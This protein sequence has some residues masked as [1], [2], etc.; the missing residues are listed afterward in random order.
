MRLFILLLLFCCFV[1]SVVA[2]KSADYESQTRSLLNYLG[3]PRI[4]TEDVNRIVT[5]REK[6]ESVSYSAEERT[7]TFEELFHELTRLTGRDTVGF[8]K[9]IRGIAKRVITDTL[10][11]F[12]PLKYSSTPLNTLAEVKKIGSGP[13]P[14][15]LIPEYRKN[16]TIYRKFI[17]QNKDK[18]TMY[19]LTLPGYNGTNP[20]PLPKNYDFSIHTWL[21]S[22]VQGTINLIKKEKIDKPLIIGSLNAGSYICTQLATKIPDQLR[23]V[24]LLNGSR[25]E[26]F[27]FRPSLSPSER[28]EQVNNDI[29]D[30]FWYLIARKKYS[31]S[32]VEARAVKPR[33]KTHPINLYSKDSSTVNE[34]FKMHITFPSITERYDLEWRTVDLTEDLRKISTPTMVIL[35]KY[36]KNRPFKNNVNGLVTH[37]QAFFESA[38][39]SNI[40]VVEIENSRDLIALDA[41]ELLTEAVQDFINNKPIPPI[42]SNLID[43]NGRVYTMV[44]FKKGSEGVKDKRKAASMQYNHLHFLYTLKAEGKISLFGASWED[45]ETRGIAIFNDES[46]ENVKKLLDEEPLIKAGHLTYEMFQWFGLPGDSLA[47]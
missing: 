22:V 8:S 24:I 14:V 42:L 27:G 19:A 5:L 10:D 43:L 25:H 4:T 45:I 30:I 28:K 40:K 47:K 46:K 41:P 34:V 1:V 36:D 2:Q 17:E 12:E 16:W 18:Y 21:N 13:I 44:V 32:E 39:Q 6:V 38:P 11:V 37:W 9:A 20:Y 26:R 29:S 15:I 23:G 33:F 35:A 7:A 31:P 3:V